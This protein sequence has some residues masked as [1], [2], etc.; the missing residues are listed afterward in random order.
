MTLDLLDRYRLMARMREFELACLEGVS[1][2]EIHGELHTGIGQEAIGAGMAGA[3]RG[4][5]AVVS[6]HRNHFHALAKG[7]SPRRLMAEIFERE[8][9]LCRG[10][11]GHMHPFDLEHNFSASGIVGASLPVALGYAYAF[12][13]EGGNR[14]AVGVIGD[15]GTNHGT[16]HETLNMAAA[17]E[18]PLIVLVE[19]NFLAISVPTSAV[20]A[21]ATIAERAAAYGA[22]GETVDGTDVEVMADAFARAVEHARSDNGPYVL[23]AICQRFQGHYEG[24][25]EQYRS[26]DERERIRREHDPLRIGRSKLVERGLAGDAAIEAIDMEAKAEMQELLAAVRSDRMPDASGALDYVFAEGAGAAR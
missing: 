10:R 19:N 11:G 18:A 15:G 14:V 13:I 7:V 26:K 9:G 6:T 21:T 5:D 20:L 22:P 1:T 4:E 3:L 24:D 23:E 17:W 25:L 12:A 2:L 16:F 8:T